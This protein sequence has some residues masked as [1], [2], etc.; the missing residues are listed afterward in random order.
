MGSSK[1]SYGACICLWQKT[2]GTET[3]RSLL[4]LIQGLG[5]LILIK[6]DELSMSINFNNEII[7]KENKDE[8]ILNN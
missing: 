4:T 3:N 6:T 1:H 5:L 8:T 2:K 7:L